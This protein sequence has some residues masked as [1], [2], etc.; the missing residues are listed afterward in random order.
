M[1]NQQELKWYQK[2]SGVI[3]LLIFFFPAGLYLMWKSELW[4]KQT[5][6]I[7]TGV[8]AVL[9]LANTGKNNKTLIGKDANGFYEH[10]FRS[11]SGTIFGVTG[12]NQAIFHKDG[13]V[14]YCNM[15]KSAKDKEASFVPCNLTKG[16]WK[17]IDKEQ[18]NVEVIFSGGNNADK[19]GVWIFTDEKYKQVR[20]PSGELLT[21]KMDLGEGM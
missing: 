3:I 16:T 19:A 10:A 7:V 13:A 2:T 20:L 15:N 6:W 17:F 11:G 1:E 5:R 4:T 8:I 9:I 18:K 21:R 12:C 14:E